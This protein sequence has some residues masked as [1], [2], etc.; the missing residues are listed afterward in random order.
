MVST[1]LSNRL[2]GKRILVTGAAGGIGLA[3]TSRLLQEGAR[4][5]AS[6]INESALRD[7]TASLSG[8]IF[9][10]TAQSVIEFR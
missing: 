2:R 8:D 9:W 4:V 5:M 7:A 3:T 10:H 1:E 6:D